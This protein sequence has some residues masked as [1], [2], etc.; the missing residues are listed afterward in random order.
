MYRDRIWCE[1]CILVS[2]SKV[3]YYRKEVG[4]VRTTTRTLKRIDTNE[5]K[6]ELYWV[7]VGQVSPGPLT[8]AV[9]SV[10]K[11]LRD[12]WWPVLGVGPGGSGNPRLIVSVVIPSGSTS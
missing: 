9:L 10:G 5:S 7:S 4:E 11:G 1:G 8:V 3:V 12:S 6:R 2:L